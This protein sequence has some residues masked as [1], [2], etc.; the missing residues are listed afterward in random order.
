MSLQV[1]F[2]A[3]Q[4]RLGQSP[5]KSLR[6]TRNMGTSHREQLERLR[7]HLE[8]LHPVPFLPPE[9]MQKDLRCHPHLGPWPPTPWGQAGE[10]AHLDSQARARLARRTSPIPTGS[11]AYQ[12]DPGVRSRQRSQATCVLAA[13]EEAVATRGYNMTRNAWRF[14]ASAQGLV[15]KGMLKQVTG[16]GGHRLLPHGQNHAS[17][18]KLKAKR[19]RR[20]RRP[21]Q[22]QSGGAPV[23][24]APIRAQ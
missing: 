24:R 1:L 6:G 17:K 8:S 18:F 21:G 12:G 16:K 22:C 11:R 19:R 5:R 4:G 3:T 13:P 20:W 14:Q 2:L 23:L 15:D 7:R 10:P 9:E